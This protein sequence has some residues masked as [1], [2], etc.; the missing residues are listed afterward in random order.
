MGQA[1]PSKREGSTTVAS[2]HLQPSLAEQEEGST[3]VAWCH[4]SAKPGRARDMVL[5][6]NAAAVGLHY[7][8]G[9]RWWPC[10]T[11]DSYDGVGYGVDEELVNPGK[12]YGGVKGVG[13]EQAGAEM[14]WPS[15]PNP[16]RN[17]TECTECTMHK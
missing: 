12:E 2:C 17:N 13:R 16:K 7:D 15:A 5:C 1:W 6:A 9:V 4:L 3:T 11:N 8:G 10:S 14:T